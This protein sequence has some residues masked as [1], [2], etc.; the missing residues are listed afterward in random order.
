MTMSSS[1]IYLRTNRRMDS[2]VYNKCSLLQMQSQS[3]LLYCTWFSDLKYIAIDN[4]S[5]LRV[6]ESIC[7][8]VILKKNLRSF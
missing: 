7:L 4:V 3:L 8:F 1:Y 2:E 5:C 6:K